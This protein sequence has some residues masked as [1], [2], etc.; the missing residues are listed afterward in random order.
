VLVGLY[1]LV[2]GQTSNEAMVNA[3]SVQTNLSG[4]SQMEVADAQY[5]DDHA[6]D[7]KEA[8]TPLS[9]VVI[10]D[11]TLED[12]WNYD[13]DG[14]ESSSTEVCANTTITLSNSSARALNLSVSNL[15]TADQVGV[16]G[17][18]PPAATAPLNVGP[19]GQYVIGQVIEGGATGLYLINAIPCGRP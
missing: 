15:N 8:I 19:E 3:A 16:I 2:R 18:M 5:G 7:K 14:G 6:V 9:E 10:T 17:E 4:N 12:P 11:A 1:F 13:G